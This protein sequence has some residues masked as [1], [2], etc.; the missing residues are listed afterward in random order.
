MKT[1]ITAFISILCMNVSGQTKYLITRQIP[2]L[3]SLGNLIPTVNSCGEE[4]FSFMVIDHFPTTADTA[5][6]VK[7]AQ[8]PVG[9]VFDLKKS[10]F[11]SDA[12]KPYQRKDHFE[13]D[14]H[15]EFY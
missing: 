13:A 3:D 15:Y 9:F 10:M 5:E 1:L 6:F 2:S 12:V 14:R 8:C 11:F 7:L 4:L